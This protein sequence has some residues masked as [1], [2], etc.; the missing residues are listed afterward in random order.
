MAHLFDFSKNYWSILFPILFCILFH[1][2]NKET[3]DCSKLQ[4]FVIS[5]QKFPLHI[6]ITKIATEKYHN[7]SMWS[8]YTGCD[9]LAKPLTGPTND[10][11]IN[12]AKFDSKKNWHAIEATKTW[13]KRRLRQKSNDEAHWWL[14]PWFWAIFHSVLDGPTLQHGK[15]SHL[16]LVCR[17]NSLWFFVV[18]TFFML[19]WRVRF[20]FKGTMCL[21]NI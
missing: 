20:F 15:K 4:Y 8:N 6:T 16:M 11:L 7:E 2:Q 19:I 12:W 18:A 1:W 5:A 13:N 10:A 3:I 9:F 21:A 17:L 14:W